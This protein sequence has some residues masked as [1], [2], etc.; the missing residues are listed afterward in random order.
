M[1]GQSYFSRDSN[2][3]M[4]F[5][6]FSM[7]TVV[8]DPVEGHTSKT[9]DH[10]LGELR[11]QTLSMGGLAIHQ[12][13]AAVDALLKGD[14]AMAARVQVHEKELN[15]LQQQI[16]REAIQLIALYQPMAGDLRMVRGIFRIIHELER[17]GDEAKKIAAFATQVASGGAHG[18][19]PG[20]TVYLK[21]MA[22]LSARLLREAMRALDE[23]DLAL[24]RS[25][26]ARD[27]E[28]DDE[29]EAALRKVFTLVM[30]GEPYLRATIET[31]FALKG[32]ERIGDHAKNIAEQVLFVLGEPT[33]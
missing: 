19:A 20:V 16:D 2:A 21:H 7:N 11:L 10:A 13:S 9:L 30:E 1:V 29:F 15:R 22:E 32:L 28:L 18:P 3:L 26:A 23:S 4:V 12:V 31:V 6:M 25:V 33:H 8:N 24:A 27:A 14:G 17:A 5:Q